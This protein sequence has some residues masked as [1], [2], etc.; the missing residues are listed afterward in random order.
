MPKH[1]HPEAFEVFCKRFELASDNICKRVSPK[2]L[3]RPVP[4]GGGSDSFS[5]HTAPDLTNLIGAVG[6]RQISCTFVNRVLR[7]GRVNACMRGQ[8]SPE[9][10][11]L[12]GPAR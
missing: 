10:L 12:A 9:G 7:G 8:I 5:E 1:L 3:V 4:C 6:G 11:R 2:P